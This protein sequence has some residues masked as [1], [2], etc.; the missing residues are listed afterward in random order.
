MKISCVFWL[1]C[2]R[3][4]FGVTLMVI[5]CAAAN[6]DQPVWF[7]ILLPA[8][9]VPATVGCAAFRLGTDAIL[10]FAAKLPVDQAALRQVARS[11]DAE[12]I[13]LPNV[14][15]LR[16]P[17]APGQ[18]LDLEAG[19][20]SFRIMIGSSARMVPIEPAISRGNVD[21]PTPATGPTV[22]LA[23]PLAGVPLLVGTVTD[24][25]AL[26]RRLQGP[27]YTTLPAW[28]GVV[29]M[30]A[31]D[32]LHLAGKRNGFV[33][34]A[35][36]SVSP[37]PVGMPRIP[38]SLLDSVPAISG[39]LGLPRADIVELRRQMVA[40]RRRL[41]EAPPLGRFTAS[42]HLARIL[43]SLGLGP[44]AHGV[45]ADLLRHDPAAIGNPQRLALLAVA[46]VVSFRPSSALEEW[47][48]SQPNAMQTDLW[49]GLAEAELGET[50]QAALLLALAMQRL[51][52]EPPLLRAQIAPVAAE[53]LVAD[54]NTG[55]AQALFAALPHDHDLDLAR[56]EALQEEHHPHAALAAFDALVGGSDQRMAGIARSRSILLRYRL[57]RIDARIAAALLARH[58]YDWRGPRHEYDVRVAM[59]RLRASAGEWPLA[60]TGLH[61]AEQLL[62]ADRDRFRQI[63]GDLFGR[64]VSTGALDQ[65]GP[66]AA[67]SVI[68]NNIGMIPEGDAGSAILKILARHLVALDLPGAAA[69]IIRDMIARSSDSVSRARLGL[70]L[71]RIEIGAGHLKQAEAALDS[72][73]SSG[74]NRE[75]AAS[76]QFVADEIT[77]RQGS[78]EALASLARSGDSSALALSAHL[79]ARRHDWKAEQSALR[80]LAVIEVPSTGPLDARAAGIV[81]QWASAASEGGD[82]ATLARLRAL[83][84]GRLPRGHDTALFDTLTANPVGQG[85]SLSAALRQIAAIEQVGATLDPV[86]LSKH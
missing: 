22:V 48:A 41:A 53:T 11:P 58:V 2:G 74:I 9:Q 73:A 1:W 60:L 15:E 64:L 38:A 49:R 79:A 34:R 85:T 40:A 4:V 52:D 68:R 75:L 69:P 30:A 72:T 43:L 32:E 27:G 71:A 82:T 23:N 42:L 7:R 13:H 10:V 20:N 19:K 39:S 36:A 3:I 50:H 62:P 56:A 47:P 21:F 24:R 35:D 14:T 83:Y 17:V 66:V 67:I 45:L 78:S 18:K 12:V 8:G 28:R 63:R 80:Q 29:V 59:A 54:G 16:L 57:H 61:R 51:L 6:A 84:L 5:G 77:A 44:E 37:L 26:R 86:K 25:T 70:G 81:T 33:L 31:S 46:D 76:R 55:A 65:L